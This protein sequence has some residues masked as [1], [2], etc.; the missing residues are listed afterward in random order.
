MVICHTDLAVIH[1]ADLELALIWHLHGYHVKFSSH[2]D[3]SK[4]SKALFLDNAIPLNYD[5]LLA[6]PYK[7]LAETYL[8]DTEET[9]DLKPKEA[10]P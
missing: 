9:D 7:N 8:L 5:K 3:A 1:K 10:S 6:Q 4:M 2:R